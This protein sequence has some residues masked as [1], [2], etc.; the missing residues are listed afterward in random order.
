MSHLPAPARGRRNPK[1]PSC[2]DGLRVL[3]RGKGTDVLHLTL[4]V[5]CSC[6]G[7]TGILSH[8]ESGLLACL[9]ASS[10]AP[11]VLP[12]WTSCGCVPQSP[13]SQKNGVWWV[14]P[15]QALR[16]SDG[17]GRSWAQ[18]HSPSPHRSTLA[19]PSWARRCLELTL[20][21]IGSAQAKRVRSKSRVSW[22]QPARGRSEP[23]LPP[24]STGWRC[25]VHP[26]QQ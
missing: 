24:C 8:R 17:R 23:A 3:W 5:R 9:T 26:R 25:S 16:S 1:V 13:H 6:W 22:D 11:C 14:L 21:F 2:R 15:C 18:P 20:V 10:L 19:P 4:N 7:G 12:A